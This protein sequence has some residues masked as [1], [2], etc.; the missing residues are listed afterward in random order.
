LRVRTHD[1]YRWSPRFSSKGTG[2][3]SRAA[4][5]CSRDQWA[6]FRAS[7]LQGI[8]TVFLPAGLGEDAVDLFEVHYTG[9]VADGFGERTQA[10]IASAA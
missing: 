6:P 10:E 5:I 7:G 9:L 3:A 1:A 4:R 8:V 2:G